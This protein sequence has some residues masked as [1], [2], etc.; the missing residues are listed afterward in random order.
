V[1]GFG[2]LP[3]F[4]QSSCPQGLD[5][6]SIRFERGAHFNILREKAPGLDWMPD[7]PDTTLINWA[8]DRAPVSSMFYTL[9]YRSSQKALVVARTALLPAPDSL[10]QVCGEWEEDPLLKPYNIFY[11]RSAATLP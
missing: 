7:L 6:I 8:E 9:D 5:L 1:K 11:V 4:E 10:W 3:Q 2:K